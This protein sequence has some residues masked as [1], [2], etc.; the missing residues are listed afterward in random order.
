MGRRT[1]PGVI[2]GSAAASTSW[3]C[4][5]GSLTTTCGATERPEA[6]DSSGLPGQSKWQPLGH[7]RTLV[8]S[9]VQLW[10]DASGRGSHFGSSGGNIAGYLSQPCWHVH[11]VAFAAPETSFSTRATYGKTHK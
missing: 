1:S 5:S 6:T 3:S 8:P 9:L 10:N 7:K 4:T 11:H 2:T